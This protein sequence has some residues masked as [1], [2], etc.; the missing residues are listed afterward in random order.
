[1]SWCPDT[2]NKI[3]VPLFK[4]EGGEWILGAIANSASDELCQLGSKLLNFYELE[5]HLTHFEF[6]KRAD[7]I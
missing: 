1:M 7:E 6:I 3:W 5:K 4:D 2:L